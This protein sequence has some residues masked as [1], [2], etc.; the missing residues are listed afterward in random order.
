VPQGTLAE[1][2]LST[3]IS[4]LKNNLPEFVLLKEEQQTVKEFPAAVG[5]WEFTFSEIRIKQQ[6]WIIIRGDAGYLL[7]FQAPGNEWDKYEP[8]FQKIREGFTVLE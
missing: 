2:V 3:R 4:T 1:L 7:F 6:N 8:E 5:M